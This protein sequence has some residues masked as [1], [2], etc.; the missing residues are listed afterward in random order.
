[1][2]RLVNIVVLGILSTV[3]PCSCERA[4]A[5]YFY[6]IG[7]PPGPSNPYSRSLYRIDLTYGSVTEVWRKSWNI[8]DYGP[9][10]G[11]T[12]NSSDGYLYGTNRDGVY[13]IDPAT[14]SL[15]IVWTRSIFSDDTL[16]TLTLNSSDGHFYGILDRSGWSSG[17]FLFRT[18]FLTDVARIGPVPTD[19]RALTYSSFD[20]YLY[21]TTSG[22]LRRIDPADGSMTFVSGLP[23]TFT[24]L[25][26]NASDG[27][28]YGAGGGSLARINPANG[29][30]T[31]L[32]DIPYIDG[33]A[34]C[35]N[36]LPPRPPQAADSNIETPSDTP[37]VIALQA[38]DDGLPDP[39]AALSYIITSLP[40][41]GILT[42]PDGTDIISVPYTLANNAD[43]VI[44][45]PVS[46]CDVTVTFTYIANDSGMAPDGGDSNEATVSVLKTNC[47][48]GTY[49]GGTGVL[50]DPYQ[51]SEPN[52]LFELEIYSGDWGKHFLMIADVNMVGYVFTTAVIAPDTD[53]TNDTWRFD[54]IPFTGVFDGADHKILNLKIDT[55]GADNDYIGLF[56]KVSGEQAQIINLGLE[57][58]SIIGGDNSERV[59]GLC[60]YNVDGTISNCYVKDVNVSGYKHVGGLGG[61]NDGRI[62]NCYVQDITVMGEDYLGGMVGFNDGGDIINCNATGEVIGR[63]KSHYLGGLCGYSYHGSSIE[64][65]YAKCDVLC[66]DDS[67]RVGGLCGGNQDGTLSHSY[68]TGSVN[69]GA[70]A[71]SFGGL[72]GISVHGTISE[73]YS[74]GSVTVGVDSD[75]G[76]GGLVGWNYWSTISQCY[77]TGPVTSGLGS[78]NLG[79]LCGYNTIGTFSNCFWDI[80]TS[81][82]TTSDGGTGKTTAEMQMSSTFFCWGY[83]PVWT[84]DEGVDYPRLWWENK[85]G[86]LITITSYGGGSGEPNSPYL[87]Y[88]AQQLNTIG[89]VPCHLDK[90]FKLMADIDLSGYTFTTAVIA[91]DTDNTNSD[92][93]GIPFTGVFDGAG[94][95]ILNLTIDVAGSN[96][97]YLGLFG[98]ISGKQAQVSNLGLENTFIT[99]GNSSRYL[100]GLCGRNGVYGGPNGGTIIN[101]YATGSVT[102]WGLAIGGLVGYNHQGTITN[103][104]ATVSV[105]GNNRVG[106]LVGYNYYSTI[107]NCYSTGSVSGKGNVGGLVGYHRSSTIANCYSTGSVEGNWSVGGLVG[108]DKLGSYTK[109]FW[110]NTVNSGLPG[111]GNTS[112]PNVIGESTANMQ[113]QTTFT[114]ASWDFV[115]ETVNG[116]EDIWFIPQQDYPHLWWEG[117]QV[118]MK[119]TPR[120]LNCRSQGNWVQA[121]LTLPEGFIVADVNS[122]RPTVLHSFGFQSA[123]L[124]VFVNKDKVVEI[125]AAFERE[126][127]CSL[128]GDWP[129]MLT[130]AGFLADGNI[131]LGT[132]N[133]RIIHPGMKVI[134]ELA[135][136]WLQGDCVHPSWCDGIDMNRDSLV[137]LADYALLMNINVEFV[138]D[139]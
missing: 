65:S 43:S 139:E 78:S 127:F 82:Q 28:L 97:D 122:E 130:V 79:G 116:V 22:S 107:T 39:P 125:E 50:D 24:G 31:T 53:N 132:S 3:G 1:M 45:T 27:Y 58:V 67:G 106:G 52:D 77:A 57:K 30:M 104:Y 38:V 136:Y 137:N 92:F 98:M 126:A 47:S 133:V 49:S 90:H 103:C 17:A 9:I 21:G 51:I 129:Q 29:S 44:Y 96:N 33:L 91:A 86:E 20:G 15:T 110:D 54:G 94:H 66:G 112:D 99:G 121:H 56:G 81:G 18:P 75:Y 100:G 36:S 62:S 120:T 35:P 63:N 37:I 41:Q 8:L 60:G 131:F 26:Y 80:D 134:E 109:A 87:I 64:N 10:R 59:G 111:I 101:C 88:T 16:Q 93:D 95:K 6:G 12:F 11:L 70:N 76:L 55:A 74:I 85:P 84:I 114:D 135:S 25:A 108:Y 40:N 19:I 73:C 46:E 2:K 23:V 115:G 124:Y 128:A 34:Y 102:G 48:G 138:N 118:P 123:P 83:E 14:G 42:D 69:G 113:T 4:V 89:L 105:S 119:L 61:R 7:E 71:Y 68:A 72:C 5:G 117:M 13:R 32:F